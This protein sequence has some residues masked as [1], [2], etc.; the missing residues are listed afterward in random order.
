[1]P[2]A[3]IFGSPNADKKALVVH[4]LGACCCPFNA[5]DLRLSVAYDSD[6][7][8]SRQEPL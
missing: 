5:S 4:G 3:L 2:S 1:M 7:A 8:C 6:L